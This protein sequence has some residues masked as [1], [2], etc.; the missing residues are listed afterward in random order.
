VCACDCS[1]IVYGRDSIPHLG[2]NSF[3]ELRISSFTAPNLTSTIQGES[4]HDTSCRMWLY[5]PACSSDRTSGEGLK[6]P[7]RSTPEF[8]INEFRTALQGMFGQM[9]TS[10]DEEGKKEQGAAIAARV[11]TALFKDQDL[12]IVSDGRRPATLDKCTKEVT[13]YVKDM[14]GFF[15]RKSAWLYR[16]MHTNN[17]F[18]KPQYA[19]PKRK[20]A[21][22]GRGSIGLPDPLETLLMIHGKGFTTVRRARLHLDMPGDNTSRGMSGIPLKSEYQSKLQTSLATKRAILV[23]VANQTGGADD[24]CPCIIVDGDAD[25]FAADPADPADPADADSIDQGNDAELMSETPDEC[26]VPL[27]PWEPH[28]KVYRELFNM[29][30]TRRKN[31]GGF[32]V[33]I[34]DFTPG[35]VLL[36]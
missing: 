2:F 6:N 20:R 19:A 25:G 8:D 4:V 28:E 30:G 27:F 24:S 22:G 3:V 26:I 14:P 35:A 7:F 10:A 13:K 36:G 12:L 17:E 15:G 33:R 31:G 34:V 1:S 32:A 29:F 5:F 16:M 21:G 11:A 9:M 23:G 18:V